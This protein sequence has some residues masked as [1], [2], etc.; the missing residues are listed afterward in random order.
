[1][2]VGQNSFSRVRMAQASEVGN[3]STKITTRIATS[4]NAITNPTFRLLRLCSEVYASRF[5]R[6]GLCVKV[7]A[8]K[9]YASDGTGTLEE[10]R[11]LRIERELSLSSIGDDF[12]VWT[13]LL[14]R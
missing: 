11:L 9:V 10:Q 8:S 1:M 14:K 6:Q 12:F 4:A 13:S 5:M 2:E 7:Y 3:P